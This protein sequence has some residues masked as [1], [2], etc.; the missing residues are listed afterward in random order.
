MTIIKVLLNSRAK[1]V[2][3]TTFVADFMRYLLADD[4]NFVLKMYIIPRII[5]SSKFP[6]VQ[7]NRK[8]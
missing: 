6:T 1:I 7:N 2:V 5:K 3:Q 8:K 4:L